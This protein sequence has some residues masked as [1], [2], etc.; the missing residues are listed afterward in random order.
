MAIPEYQEESGAIIYR[1]T[2]EEREYLKT[3]KNLE[4][5]NKELRDE[6]DDL[7]GKYKE[8]ERLVKQSIIKEE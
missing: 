6:L 2:P 8:L 7:R 3:K 1:L 4:N 5:E